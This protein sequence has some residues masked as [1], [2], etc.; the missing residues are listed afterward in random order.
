MG[1]AAWVFFLEAG[2]AMGLLVLIV[3]WTMFSRPRMP[4]DQRPPATPSATPAPPPAAP[5]STAEQENKP[6]E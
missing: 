2:A 5:K 6:A 1:E 4:P 3:W